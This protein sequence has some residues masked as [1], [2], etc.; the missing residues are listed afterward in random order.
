M[1]WI[2]RI[3]VGL[4]MLVVVAVAALLLMPSD[5]VAALVGRQ[6]AAATGQEMTTGG[7]RATLWP[8]PGVTLSDVRVA[9][10]GGGAPLLEARSL[11]VGV[12][13]AALWGGDVRVRQVVLDGAVIRLVRRADGTVNWAKAAGPADAGSGGTGSGGTG[14]AGVA[15]DV[16][17]LV[18]P[19]G[20]ITD[21]TVI[22]TDEGAGTTWEAQALDVTLRLPGGGAPGTAEFAGRVN[23]TDLSGAA[24]VGDLAGALSG[25]VVPVTMR[26]TSGASEV[27]FTGRAG[28][29][30]SAATGRVEAVL[31]DPAGFAGVLGQDL[32][33]LPQGLGRERAE[34]SGD[35]TWTAERSLHLRGGRLALDGTAFQG[36][37]DLTTAGDRPKLTA[38]LTAGALV[39]PESVA[40]AGGGGSGGGGAARAKGWPTEVIDASGLGLMDAEV[41]IQAES[42]AAGGVTLAPVDATLSVDRARGVIDIARMG[43]FGGIVS[44]QVVMN[45]RKGLSVGGDLTAAGVD[46]QA[47]LSSVA[48]YDRLTGTGDV[49]VKFLGSG[50]SVQA[51]MAGLSGEGS[52]ALRDGEVKGVDLAGML[53]FLDA[54]RVG[55]EQETTYDSLTAT[56]VIEGGVLRND[57]LRLAA[58]LVTASGTGVADLGKR[59]LDYRVVPVAL[60]GADGTGDRRVP[61][62]ITG[63]WDD[64]SFRLDLEALAEAELKKQEEALRAKAEAELADQLGVEVQPGEDLE[65][66][67]KR[68]LEEELL[69]GLGGLLGGN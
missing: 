69:N 3:V 36:D 37:A 63:P 10:P 35:L 52:L 18:L 65:D 54:E 44:G 19:E 1:R 68:K 27:G 9:G 20:R 46:V 14:T 25:K 13:A 16:T 5:R 53:R 59:T 61:L 7:V 26:L 28:F 32:P 62:R 17:G 31:V 24:E 57:D 51:I 34:L 15:P 58:P 43:A 23:G 22:Y 66:A 21:G 38:R 2:I 8:E 4:V 33:R 67:A 55:A 6:I 39:L 45:N 47:M 42:V 12:E 30:P 29:A 41:R 49:A 50:A 64:L 48:G 40:G 11:T 56:Y 60:P